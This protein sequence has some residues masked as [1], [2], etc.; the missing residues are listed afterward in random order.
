M[1]YRGRIERIC[2]YLEKDSACANKKY[3]A[4]LS[5]RTL[6]DKKLKIQ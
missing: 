2:E 6:Y 5:Q 1:R 4:L 3:S